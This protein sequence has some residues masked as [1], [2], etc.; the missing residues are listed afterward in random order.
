V[1]LGS[2]VYAVMANDD[3][4]RT[5]IVDAATE[6]G[7]QSWPMPLPSE[8]RKSLDTEVADIANVGERNGGMLTAGVFLQEFVAPGI[9]WAHLD[10]AGPAY[11]T[12]EPHGYTVKGGT[13][14]PVRS[15]VQWLMTLGA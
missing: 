1:A 7:E 5:S 3:E 6:A 11:N 8:L 10:I 12:G 9:K 14:V 2:R 4:L 15:L 13:G